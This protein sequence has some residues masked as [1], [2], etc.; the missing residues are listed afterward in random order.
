MAICR[1]KLDYNCQFYSTATPERL[2]KLDSIHWEGIR[3]NL[4][5]FKTS[6]IEAVHIEA[7]DHH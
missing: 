1:S 6:P 7:N 2:K 5:N 3:I 4:R